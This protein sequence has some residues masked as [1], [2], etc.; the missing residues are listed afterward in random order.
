MIVESVGLSDRQDNFA[1]EETFPHP[2][3]YDHVEKGLY[4]RVLVYAALRL[5]TLTSVSDSDAK[6]GEKA[7][8]RGDMRRGAGPLATA[9]RV[10]IDLIVVMLFTVAAVMIMGGGESGFLG[11][12][13]GMFVAESANRSLKIGRS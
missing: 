1:A 4:A 10:L 12:L 6:N 11:A 5:L 3:R 13:I 9:L 7:M 2:R 8:V